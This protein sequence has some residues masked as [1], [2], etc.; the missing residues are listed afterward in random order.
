MAVKAEPFAAE[1]RN[2]L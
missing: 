2:I 1:K